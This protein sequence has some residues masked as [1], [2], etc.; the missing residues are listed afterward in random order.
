[1]A[2]VLRLIKNRP[3]FI[4]LVFLALSFAIY[5]SSINTWFVSDDFH[6]LLI[7]RDTEISARIFTTNYA[8][9]TYGGSYNP[10]LVLLFKFFYTLFGQN[11]QPYHIVSIIVHAI[12]AFLLYLLS[13]RIFKLINIS[14]SNQ[15]SILAAFFFLIW[16]VQVE[17][18]YWI[19]AWPHIWTLLFYLTSL[20]F[21]FQFRQDNLKRAYYLSLLFFAL[22]IFTK[23]IAISLPF[24][25]LLWEIY[26][27]SSKNSKKNSLSYFVALQFF[28]LALIFLIIRY[29]SIGLLF[30][31]YGSHNLQF[32]FKAFVGILPGF[33]NEYVS[34][35]FLRI[36]FF[37]IYYHFLESV[38]IVTLSSLALYFYY[39]LKKKAWFNFTLFTSLL[40]SLG[41]V[42]LVGL[43]RSTFAG[44]RYLYIASIFWV[45]WFTYIFAI[46]K[47]KYRL[48]II[49]I[50]F[51]TIVFLAVINYKANLW[52]EGSSM[53]KQIV[54][55]YKY[56][57]TDQKQ[58]FVTVGLPDNM[59]GAEVFRNNLSQALTFSYPDNPP[60]I[61]ALPVYVRL[62]PANKNNQLLKWRKDDLGFFA[63]SIDGSF[64]VTGITSIELEG[65]YFEL[66]NYNYQNFTANTI[67]LI[68][69]EEKK[70]D[71]VSG[72]LKILSFDRG[73]LIVIE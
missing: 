55:S 33:L 53:S 50:I 51:L 28:A 54:D 4:C 47:I 45:L 58:S 69:R 5:F 1:M 2:S 63:E 9:E 42:L 24:V 20:L 8:G 52:S 41:P 65:F 40:V 35:S 61:I 22:A 70:G 16:P 18:V 38:V 27:I 15:L 68:P 48:K 49:I 12:N 3:I 31:Y 57:K 29:L 26:F 39:L 43:H 46:I 36:I 14:N 19:S 17:T 23:E 73:K 64:V 56:I 62:N 7:A 13:K 34:F 71:L 72:K 66:W 30:G 11:H 32:D 37:K 44:D 6:W 60:E 59:S 67:R 25:I 21:Y 10:I